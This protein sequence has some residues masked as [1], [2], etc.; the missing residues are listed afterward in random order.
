MAIATTHAPTMKLKRTTL[1]DAARDT[2]GDALQAALADMI[3]LSLQAKQAHWVV[4]GPGFRSIH[5]ELDEL[6][7]AYRIASDEIAERMTALNIAPDG[8]AQ[9]VARQSGLEAFPEGPVMDVNVRTLIADR[10]AT[11]VNRLRL[12]QDAV[13]EVDAVSEDVLI[14]IIQTLEK[15]L[16]MMQAQE[17]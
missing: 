12:H 17:K 6:V 7:D 1:S 2:V 9:T 3:D 4:M 15:Q 16:W 10:I 8:R 13:G 5:L 14:G 11:V